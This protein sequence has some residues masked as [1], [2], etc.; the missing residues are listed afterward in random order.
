MINVFTH[1][2]C[3]AHLLYDAV[4]YLCPPVHL[5]NRTSVE[6]A[7]QKNNFLISHSKHA[8]GSQKNHLNETVLLYTQ[9]MLKLMGKKIFTILPSKIL[10][11]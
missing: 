5:S 7:Y 2:M 6:T 4:P 3:L 1:L 9:N 10:F 8:V 11:F